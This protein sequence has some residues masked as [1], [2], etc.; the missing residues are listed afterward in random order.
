MIKLKEGQKI[1]DE[2]GNVY[3][4]EKNDLIESKLNESM[5]ILP[6]EVLVDGKITTKGDV[7]FGENKVKSNPSLKRLPYKVAWFNRNSDGSVVFRIEIQ[8]SEDEWFYSILG[9]NTTREAQI[10][11]WDV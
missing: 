11:G 4:T 7:K 3:L 9:Y 6:Y 8:V 10:D 5:T 1:L 2:Q